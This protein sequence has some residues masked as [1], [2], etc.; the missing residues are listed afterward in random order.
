LHWEIVCSKA[1]IVIG[2]WL[3]NLD[4]SPCVLLKCFLY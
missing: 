1:V 4:V 2:S 3:L